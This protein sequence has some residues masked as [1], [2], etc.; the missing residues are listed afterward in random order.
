MNHSRE[1]TREALIESSSCAATERNPSIHIVSQQSQQLAASQKFK[2][3]G[4]RASERL[5]L[6]ILVIRRLRR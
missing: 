6:K 5:H 3:K 4:A 1:Q 2:F